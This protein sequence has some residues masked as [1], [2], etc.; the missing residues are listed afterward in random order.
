MSALNP[1]IITSVA[2]KACKS[3]MNMA[4]VVSASLIEEMEKEQKETIKSKK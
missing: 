3:L 4:P 2:S 1:E